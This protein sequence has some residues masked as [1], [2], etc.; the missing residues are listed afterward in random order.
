MDS[1]YDDLLELEK[2]ILKKFGLPSTFSNRA[3]IEV[4]GLGNDLSDE[5]IEHFIDELADKSEEYLTSPVSSDKQQLLMAREE[6]TF[7]DDVFAKLNF[8]GNSYQ[9]FIYE[10][11]FCK[12]KIDDDAAFAEMKKAESFSDEVNQITAFSKSRDKIITTLKIAGASFYEEYY[13]FVKYAKLSKKEMKR[14][15]NMEKCFFN[16]EFMPE[17][18][19][20]KKL[21]KLKVKKYLCGYYITQK[22][23]I[24]FVMFTENSKPYFIHLTLNEL[25]RLLENTL[26]TSN[27]NLIIREI[28]DTLELSNGYDDDYYSLATCGG[29]YLILE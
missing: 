3:V 26:Q 23:N 14:I 9:V 2:E 12:Y 29:Q 4:F 1:D 17:F 7:F 10:E 16:S 25:C 8:S 6:Y 13:Q 20:A 18:I 11:L 28:K 24:L 22:K 21:L 15:K 19:D 5:S 27:A